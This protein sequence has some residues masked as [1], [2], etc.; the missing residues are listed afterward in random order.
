MTSNPPQPLPLTVASMPAIFVPSSPNHWYS[1]LGRAPYSNAYIPDPCPALAYPRM[2]FPS[3]ETATRICETLQKLANIRQVYFF[4][5]TI[6]VE[7]DN[8]DGQSYEPK[9]LP[10][11]VATLP[12]T[13][14]HSKDPFLDIM[15]DCVRERV[16]DP[17]HYLP[18]PRIGPLPQ[19]GTNYLA[20]PGWGFLCPGMRVSTG[21]GLSNG[22]YA[23]AVAS[24]TS[25]VLLQ[26]GNLRYLTVAN[27]GFLGHDEVHHPTD[28]DDKVGDIIDR[29]PEID[30][31]M[32][33]LTPATSTHFLN[34]VY[35]K[36]APPTRLLDSSA[37]SP[38]SWFEVDTMS[39]GLLSFMFEGVKMERPVRPQGHPPVPCCHWRRDIVMRIFGAKNQDLIDGMC[40]APFVEC[41]TGAVAGFFHLANGDHA[42]CAT[43]DDLI[44]EG[45]SIC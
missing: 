36:A 8:S 38:G 31:A 12:V 25:G 17:S 4:P 37:M 40:G 13:Y 26:K 18:G 9:S 2:S 33:K 1:M 35:F 44:A 24:T 34:N 21:P 32:V 3:H 11:K 23:D 29:Y 7:L 15:K 42:V 30:V 5:L 19:D 16:I 41:D 22:R 43:V 6:V 39:T 10:S 27:H 20:Q 28:S 14:H 45:W